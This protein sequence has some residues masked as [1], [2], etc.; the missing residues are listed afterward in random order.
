MYPEGSIIFKYDLVRQWVAE[1]FLAASEGQ[2]MEQVAGMYFDE[3][4][5]RRFIQPVSINFYNEVVSCTVHDVVH[6]LIAHK[7]VEENF[8]VVVDHNQ[9]ILALSHKVRR[10]SLQLGDAK[11]AK[12]PANI[13]KSQVRSLGYFGVSECMP[14][15][16]EFK[17]VRV[18]NLQLSGHHNG[19][20]DLAID[21]TGISELFLLIYLKIVCD[22]CIKLPGCMRGLQC[23]ETLDVMDTPKGTHVPWDIIYLPYLLHLSLPLNTNL[24]DWAVSTDSLGMMNHL[25]DL[26]ISTS[27][28][29]DHDH[30]KRSMAALGTL[31][32]GHGSLNT[33]KLVAHGSS[34]RYGDA[35]EATINYWLPVAPPHNL[36]RFECYRHSG[37]IFDD[38]LWRMRQLGNLCILK[39]KVME[40][41]V[42]DVDTLRGL[43]ALA[44]L[45]LYVETSPDIKIIFGSAAGFT[46]LKYLKLRFMSGIAWLRFEAD[47]MPNLLKLRLVFDAIPQLDQRLELYSK[48]DQW[49]QYRH[50]TALISIE[51]M[52][53]LREV[54]A[55]FEGASADLKYVSRIGVVI[56]HASNPIIDVQLVDSGSHGDKRY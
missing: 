50:G 13:R 48:S 4:V 26:Y 31:I 15:I 36:Q 7:S 1:G 51:H 32:G 9:K 42:E 27:P 22:V 33:V 34:V 20:Q 29:S 2:N 14:C 25:V 8:V 37:I 18:L 35:S 39:I 11:Y 41:P 3:L 23:L 21:L 56:N 6:D 49:K 52:P 43:P 46:A 55:K 38:I 44:A 40:L 54:S 16:G 17:L 47:A 10:L 5:D 45:S 19:D 12:I 28:S 30:V 24:L 53:H